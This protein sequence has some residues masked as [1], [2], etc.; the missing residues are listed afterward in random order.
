LIVVGDGLE[1]PANVAAL[2]DA[3]TLCGV[4]WALIDDA[5]Q[6]EALAAGPGPLL[7]LENAPGATPLHGLRLPPGP[8]PV[9]VVGNE[10]RGVSREL[11]RAA[12]KVIA[13]PMASR[14]GAARGVDTLNVAA[15][16]AV[17]LHA[18]TGRGSDRPVQLRAD[19]AARRPRLLLVN[20]AHGPDASA[21]LGSALRSA[22]AFGWS[23]A[24]VDDPAWFAGDRAERA[25]GRAAAR[26]AKSPLRVL[27][28][29][30]HGEVLR[31][32]PR[33]DGP[34]LHRLDLARPELLVVIGGPGPGHASLGLEPGPARLRLIASIALAEVARQVGTRLRPG[35]KRGW[36]DGLE[37]VEAVSAPG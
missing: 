8:A 20:E 14:I 22:A 35:R 10:R 3:A 15:A 19:P 4:G 18:L 26:Q 36:E 28:S 12:D 24:F 33:G 30:P 11:L 6:R 2:R 1:T 9:L 29:V 21:E 34:P 17:A 16:A 37:L 32:S 31:V 13:I 7:V 23:E 27:P 25:S 5:G